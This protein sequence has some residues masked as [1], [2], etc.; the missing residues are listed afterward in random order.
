MAKIPVYTATQDLDTAA[1]SMPRVSVD[2]S[3]FSAIAQAGNALSQLGARY[4]ELQARQE[5]FGLR[6][7]ESAWLEQFA[8]EDDEAV[9]NI[10]VNGAGYTETRAKAFDERAQEFIGKLPDHARTEYSARIGQQRD[11]YLRQWAGTEAAQAGKYSISEIEKFS[12]TARQSIFNNPDDLDNQVREARERIMLA[13]GLTTDQRTQ[14][15]KQVDEN[16]R[17]IAAQRIAGDNP[18]E[19]ARLMGVRLGVPGSTARGAP[20]DPS[21]KGWVERESK[22]WAPRAQRAAG[23]LQAESGLPA[24]AIAGLLGNVVQESR[25]NTSARNKGDG[26]D[27]SD[28]IGI[29]QW[30]SSRATGLKKFAAE[31]GKDWTDFDTQVRY[32][33]QEMKTTERRTYDRLMNAKTVEEAAGIAVG[34]FRPAGW[35]SSDPSGSHGFKYRVANA[36]KIAGLDPTGPQSS[37]TT[38]NGG[39]GPA[40]K[41]DPR[42]EALPFETR[43]KLVQ[44]AQRNANAA[45]VTARAS[46]ENR[47]RDA[48]AAF[49]SVGRFDAAPTREEFVRAYGPEE[50]PKRADRLDDIKRLGDD[51]RSLQSMTQEEMRGAVAGYAPTLGE[52]FRDQAGR[53]QAM[54]RAAAEVIKR[55][56]EDP[57]AEVARTSPAVQQAYDAFQK[58]FSGTTEDRRTAAR[59]YAAVSLAEQDRL[60][61]R[62]KTIL[63]ANVVEA[64]QADLLRA[65]KEGQAQNVARRIQD[66]ADSWGE[67]WPKV[68]EQMAGKDGLPGYALVIGAMNRP[69]QRRAAE[70]LAEAIAVGKKPL[71]ESLKKDDVSGIRDEVETRMAGFAATLRDNP[72]SARTL[73]TFRE[74]VHMLALSYARQGDTPSRAAQRAYADVLGKK[75]HPLGSSSFRVP[76][77]RNLSSVTAGASAFMRGLDKEGLDVPE[78]AGGKDKEYAKSSYLRALSGNSFWV[79]SP[80]EDGLVLY[81]GATRSVVTSGGKPVT[82]T[83]DELEKR[84]KPFAGDPRK[85]PAPQGVPDAFEFGGMPSAR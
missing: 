54:Q 68:F 64:M 35:N 55:R 39:A 31:Q 45:M 48:E 47:A 49:L 78:W 22:N 73:Q 79:T 80:R 63:P 25:L 28:S 57:A 72:G 3:A 1:R 29:V 27:G 77:E 36:Q 74:G 38:T 83:W 13:P 84:G 76:I 19:M 46:V 65:G 56:E 52:G 17:A 11:R 60:G 16:F 5:A 10:P 9:R 82:L 42:F 8:R 43:M 40:L 70:Q 61:I 20:Q 34:F 44:D 18:G 15:F 33:V 69:D 26:R 50:G 14:L 51:I 32:L 62:D 75:Y 6:S 53:Q 41:A 85:T 23:I 4:G 12:T 7:Q 21:V 2:T 59:A 66:M 58:S 81:E 30:N 71:E 67:H 37:M 24:V